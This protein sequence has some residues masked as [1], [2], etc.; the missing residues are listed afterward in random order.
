MHRDKSIKLIDF[1]ANSKI[2]AKITIYEKAF[3]WVL[4]KQR[5]TWLQANIIGLDK[6][7]FEDVMESLLTESAMAVVQSG[8]KSAKLP[9]IEERLRKQDDG[10]V[11]IVDKLRQKEGDKALNTALGTFYIRATDNQE[12]GVEFYHKSFS[13]FLCAKRLYISF[14]DWT[15]KVKV[16]RRKE[17]YHINDEQLA[18]QIYPN[19][20]R[21][22]HPRFGGDECEPINKRS[23]ATS[24]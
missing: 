9:M 20:S 11:R 21:I 6:D 7:N 2:Q 4:T 22:P 24:S 3:Q 10:L 12:G 17:S 8:G 19:V 13:E 14:E 16:S 5:E 23:E 18:S 1:Q 15:T